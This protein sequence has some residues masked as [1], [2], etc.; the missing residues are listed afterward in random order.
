MQNKD[1]LIRF[2]GR[3][4]TLISVF[5][6]LAILVTAVREIE[7][8]TMSGGE[9]AQRVISLGSKAR[10]CHLVTSEVERQVPEIKCV[11]RTP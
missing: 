6:C 2:D 5:F 9:W 3:A 10:G 8:E 4:A 7:Q 11:F 1:K